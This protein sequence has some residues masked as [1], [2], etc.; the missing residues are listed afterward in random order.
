MKRILS[1]LTILLALCLPI[2]SFAICPPAPTPGG[3]WVFP[4]GFCDNTLLVCPTSE[5]ETIGAAMNAADAGDIV[6]VAEGTYTE[7]VVFPHDNITLRAQGSAENT[8]ITQ[9]TGTT[10]DFSTTSGCTLD[11]FT[12]ILSA[13]TAT[14]DRAIFSSNDSTADYN[15]VKNCIITVDETGDAFVLYGIDINDGAFR[16]LNN[17]ISITQSDDSAVYAIWNGAANAFEV[18][19]NFITVDQNATGAFMSVALAHS[20][21]AGS[22]LYASENVITLDSTHT[23]ASIAHG[24]YAS[25]IDNYIDGNTIT[26]I[27]AAAGAATAISSFANDTGYY[28]GNLINAT[29]TDS[30]AMWADFPASS[31]GYATGNNI[32]GDGVFG[33]G[34]TIYLGV[35][36]IN[37][38]GVGVTQTNFVTVE[39]SAD[40]VTLTALECSDT[41]ITNRG[42]DG[43]DD[44]TFILPDADTV[45]GAGL[46]FKYINAVTDG[47]N[48][49]YFDPEGTTTKIYLDGTPMTDGFRIVWTNP[50]IGEGMTCHTFTL[51]GTTYDWACD[52]INGLVTNAGS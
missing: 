16:L 27:V 11:G 14:E 39:K 50:T 6:L 47:D 42:W 29:T 32:I 18:R 3:D 21:G 7:A 12:V 26:V 13:A 35:N 8:I 28:T 30:D 37:G 4:G 46:K 51:D 1:I 15:T 49:I 2:T 44:Q 34:G 31:I 38:S 10:V 17:T 19:G 43:A 33:I 25:A 45:V 23:G 36:Q 5:Y 24:I 48:N 52:S 22:V 20:A 41:L 9:P 40:A